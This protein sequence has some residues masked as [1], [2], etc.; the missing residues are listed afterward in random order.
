[1][2]EARRLA[3]RIAAM[4]KL[5]HLRCSPRAGLG[6]VAPA[7]TRSS[8][9]SARRGRS[10][11]IDVHGSLARSAARVRRRRRSRP[12]TRVQ[13]GRAFT[14]AERDALAVIERMAVRFAL[15]DRVLISTPMW[16]FGIPYK[17]KQ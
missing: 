13:A 8:R 17:L 15:A 4:P 9:A 16:N 14:D 12:N 7:P 6:F 3:R 10:W 11:D 2:R 1:M 5:F